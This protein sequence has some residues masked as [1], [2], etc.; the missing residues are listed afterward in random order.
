PG[1]WLVVHRLRARGGGPWSDRAAKR[2]RRVAGVP[3]G[4]RGLDDGGDRA[5]SRG[6]GLARR[7]RSG[8]HMTPRTRNHPAWWAFIAHRISGIALALFL[9]A[10]FMAFASA[11]RGVAAL[12]DF[13]RWS[14]LPLVIAGEY[15]L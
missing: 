3:R 14:A 9:P 5:R 2:R 1:V 10:H 15:V 6:Y 7:G 8:G 12:D 13:L 4:G 11:L